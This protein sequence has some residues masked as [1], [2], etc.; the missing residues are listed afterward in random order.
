MILKKGKDYK[1]SLDNEQYEKLF[2]FYINT[3]SQYYF[4]PN[5]KDKLI[6]SERI[7]Q[8]MKLNLKNTLTNF[9]NNIIYSH[10]KYINRFIKCY[11]NNVFKNKLEY[12]RQ[13]KK[14]STYE[15]IKRHNK[16]DLCGNKIVNVMDFYLDFFK[17]QKK[18][19]IDYD[20]RV[21]KQFNTY[22]GEKIEKKYI[23]RSANN[24][25][26]EDLD[27][28]KAFEENLSEYK[29]RIKKILIENEPINE[30]DPQFIKDIITIKNSIIPT[31]VK[32]YKDDLKKNPYNFI[33]GMIYINNYLEK[34]QSKTFN[35]FPTRKNFIPRNIIIDATS[36]NV[37]FCKN[38]FKNI[39][40]NK[41]EIYKTIFSFPDN[42]YKLNGYVFSGTIHTDGVSISLIFETD[43]K[44]K[45][46]LKVKK[47]KNDAKN[48]ELRNKKNAEDK[49]YKEYNIVEIQNFI[50]NNE[51]ILKNL[52]E[53]IDED[54]IFKV[55]SSIDESKRM[56]DEFNKEI[57]KRMNKYINDTRKEKEE[58]NLNKEEKKDKKKEEDKK[59][60]V[61]KIKKLKEESEG[62]ELRKINRKGKEFYYLDDLTEEEL[63]KVEK[64]KKMYIDQG[65]INLIYVLIEKDGKDV[66]IKYSGKERAF[67]LKTKEH[68]KNMKKMYLNY[69]ITKE[70]QES[71]EI[72][73][74]SSN[75]ETIKSNMEQINKTFMATY[76]KYLNE[77]LRKEKL[78]IYIDKQKAEKSLINKI[79][80]QLGLTNIN[81]LKEYTLIIGD[82]KGNNSLKNSKSTLGIGMKRLLKKYV[83]EMYLIDEYNT[84]KICNMLHEEEV[85]TEEKI[86]ELKSISKKGEVKI[87]SK[88]MHEI[89][90]FKM[91]KQR[92][93]CKKNFIYDDTNEEK[94]TI[95]G[96]DIIQ[97]NRYIQ[98]DKNAVLNFRTILSH[99]ILN[100]R[101]RPK[102]FVRSEKSTCRGS[103]PRKATVA[104]E[105]YSSSIGEPKK[106]K[107]KKA[108][109]VKT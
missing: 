85:K 32:S 64:S 77:K 28:I 33:G 75:A 86:M 57:K 24:F 107:K 42:Y 17:M 39:T 48:I 35:V 14:A 22:L 45:E 4:N 90:T 30:N 108:K 101:E 26:K 93:L 12:N 99:Y 62:D 10:E 54:E 60:Y 94:V 15:M 74:K 88:K 69:G 47:I 6:C 83:K 56:L 104:K 41:L 13:I 80:K 51:K 55:S 23:I 67:N 43:E 44:Y 37:A 84:S 81:E 82:W 63:K 91:Q 76:E 109:K 27:K 18:Y 29:K 98:R 34:I 106:L 95:E 49:L 21:L 102:A 103:K 9:D 2:N 92:I 65:K 70:Q 97:I 1:P 38:S 52:K 20:D 5:G 87:I 61:K 50:K 72:N 105:S 66:F 59:E 40:N 96:K 8:I 73:K 36:M 78:E 46:S 68:I 25:F 31:I 53:K 11:L 89:L 71:I 58:K 7:D 100:N 16:T 3:F 79:V 19:N